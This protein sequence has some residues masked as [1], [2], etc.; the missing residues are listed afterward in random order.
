[1]R[2]KYIKVSELKEELACLAAEKFSVVDP[3]YEHLLKVLETVE[4]IIDTKIRQYDQA[5]VRIGRWIPDGFELG[6][7]KYKC[8]MCNALVYWPT[9]RGNPKMPRCPSCQTK[10]EVLQDERTDI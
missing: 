6:Y 1:M 3:T 8:S 4:Q 9:G 2:E 5:E 10:M 7:R